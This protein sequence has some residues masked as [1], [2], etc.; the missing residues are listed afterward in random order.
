M[1]T[2]IHNVNERT[3]RHGARLAVRAGLRGAGSAAAS[4]FGD[5]FGRAKG[6]PAEGGLDAAQRQWLRYESISTN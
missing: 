6:W 4:A 2:S 1:G 5:L 3:A